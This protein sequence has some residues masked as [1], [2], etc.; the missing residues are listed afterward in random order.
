MW[1]S[2]QKRPIRRPR[3]RWN[4]RV[5]EDLKLLGIRE[6]ETRALERHSEA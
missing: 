4:D 3:Q 5:N 6:G 2:D 1:K